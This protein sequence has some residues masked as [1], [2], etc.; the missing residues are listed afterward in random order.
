MERKKIS[1]WKLSKIKI[2]S[3]SRLPLSI[4]PNVNILSS[5][6]KSCAPIST[7]LS[8]MSHKNEK[9]EYPIRSSTKIYV[10][11]NLKYISNAPKFYGSDILLI[12][13][14]EASEDPTCGSHWTIQKS[15]GFTW[16]SP[17]EYLSS[18][19]CSSIFPPALSNIN[20]ICIPI[21][22]YHPYII[23]ILIYCAVN[24]CLIPEKN[25]YIPS[26]DQFGDMYNIEYPSGGSKMVQRG[27]FEMSLDTSRFTMEIKSPDLPSILAS[28]GINRL[29]A[30]THKYHLR[31]PCNFQ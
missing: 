4:I 8:S 10:G 28:P 17:E 19:N 3:I 2:W 6:T 16:H 20:H 26:P 1:P 31:P 18:E 30:T 29:F 24:G 22:I 5:Q 11:R 23:N 27:I 9:S 15:D 21:N 13:Y 12:I 25:V 7:K 14:K